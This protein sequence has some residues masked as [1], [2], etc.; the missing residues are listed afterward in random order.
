MAFATLDMMA[1]SRAK[2]A[3]MPDV[4]IEKLLIG[5]DNHTGPDRRR[6]QRFKCDASVRS[7][8]GGAT[9]TRKTQHAFAR[10][11]A[12]TRE[13]S[14]VLSHHVRVAGDRVGQPSTEK[15]PRG[16]RPIRATAPRPD[17][18][19]SARKAPDRRLASRPVPN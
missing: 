15:K 14:S 6:I 9:V 5:P 4:E 18:R 10:R 2:L 3:C 19:H 11:R 1:S 17:F 16:G 13:A 12:G 8:A 7:F